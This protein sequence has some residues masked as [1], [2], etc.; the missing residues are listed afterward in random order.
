MTVSRRWIVSIGGAIATIGLGYGLLPDR[1]PVTLPAPEVM[2]VK[3]A[4]SPAAATPALPGDRT[5]APPA[6]LLD[7]APPVVRAL[8]DSIDDASRDA[9]AARAVQRVFADNPQL[10]DI[11]AT[12]GASRCEVHGNAPGDDTSV[13]MVLRDGAFLDRLGAMGMTAGMEMV[14]QRGEASGF[15]VFL[16]RGTPVPS[17]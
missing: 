13:R 1:A 16:E 9:G 5:P 15:I 10:T 11:V 6:A 2:I 4:P 12:C 3:A 14:G 7:E 17:R 8:H